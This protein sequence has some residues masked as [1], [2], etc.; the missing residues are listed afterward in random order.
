MRLAI[1]LLFFNFLTLC[2]LAQAQAQS[3]ASL[4]DAEFITKEVRHELLMLPYLD[5]FD[6]LE[7]R[8]DGSEVTLTGQVT[9]PQLKSDAERAAKR[10]EGVT[11]VNNEI[12][13]LP[14]SPSDD[15][16]RLRLFHVIYGYAGLQKYAL[17]VNK[18]IRMNV[19]MGHGK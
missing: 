18:P 13:V 3:E 17:G 8:V 2:G 10:I 5:V 14:L 7:Y 6:Y 15:R 4:S 19:S 12:E 11:Y 16:L 1:F 9:R